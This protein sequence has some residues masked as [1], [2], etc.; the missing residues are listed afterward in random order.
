MVSLIAAFLIYKNF[1]APA[2]FT[3][4]KS[5]AVL[6]FEN[7]GTNNS[8]EYISDG[9]TQDIINNLSKVSSLQKVIA[10]FSVKG[11]KNTKKTVKQI[12]DE[13]GVAAILTGTIERERDNIHIVAELV[14]V[15]SGKRLWGENYNYKSKD[16]LSIQSS[17]AGEIVNALQ[18]SLTPE[19]KKNLS[20]HYTENV[21]AYKFYRKGRFFWDQRNTASYDSA[22]VYYKKAIEL[23][24][25]Y[26]LAYSGLADCYTFN[27]KG[28]SQ[29]EAI[30]IA[31]EYAQKALSLDSTLTEAWTTIGFIQSHFD[32]DW[33][34]AKILFEKIIKD[35]PNYPIVHLYYGNV[36]LALGKSDEVI[37][38]TKKA[39]SLDPLSAVINYVLGREYYDL[40]K[41]D[42]AIIQLQKNINLNPKFLNS[43]VPLG[44]SYVQKKMYADAIIPFPNYLKKHGT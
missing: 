7:A 13:L 1:S 4:D 2:G 31:R 42:S 20:K 23:D 25:D 10:W 26:A 27:Q 39:L 16:I 8:E 38:E 40:K 6:P 9:I 17:L 37:A 30:P 11:F 18:A 22:E 44:Q 3:G 33:T 29:L 19:E 36:L 15:N 43:N 5:I 32:Y 41:Y 24:P 28:L 12:A 34:G 21:D 14:D 35:D